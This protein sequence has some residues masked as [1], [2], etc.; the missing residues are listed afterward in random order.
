MIRYNSYRSSSF[1]FVDISVPS[2]L[3]SSVGRCE[4]WPGLL[5]ECSQHTHR[6]TMA[7]ASVKVA[8][9][10]RPFNSREISKDSKCIIQMSGNTTSKY[11]TASEPQC[12]H[13]EHP[14]VKSL[15]I[16]KR[17]KF[18]DHHF[19]CVSKYCFRLRALCLSVCLTSSA[20]FHKGSHFEMMWDS[21]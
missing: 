13:D 19:Y 3:Y 15:R 9:R 16:L 21:S 11:P 18:I 1:L 12:F 7:G 14:A 20:G 10:V 2:M 5:K 17:L 6:G 4:H 8:V